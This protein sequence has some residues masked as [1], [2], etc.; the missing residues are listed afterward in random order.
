MCNLPKAPIETVVDA[1]DKKVNIIMIVAIAVP[2]VCLIIAGVLLYV[3]CI[4]KRGEMKV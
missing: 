3:F 2:V 1:K 4:R